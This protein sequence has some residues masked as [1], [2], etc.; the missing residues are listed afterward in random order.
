MKT[1]T[2]AD[3]V[4]LMMVLM[5]KLYADERNRDVTRYRTSWP[6]LYDLT[7]VDRL[8]SEYISA[9]REELR[10]L[11]WL[12]DINGAE[13]SVVSIEKRHTWAKLGTQ[14]LTKAN[15]LNAGEE[16]LSREYAAV[17]TRLDEKAHKRASNKAAD[18]AD[19]TVAEVASSDD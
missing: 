19:S 15:L 2:P 11:G 17:C 3:V 5:A 12:L 16:E 10:D 1:P 18:N 13:I 14:R 7:G 8:R 6:A 4:A 9:L